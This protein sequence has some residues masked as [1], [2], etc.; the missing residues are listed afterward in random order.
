MSDNPND[1]ILEGEVK[2]LTITSADQFLPALTLEEARERYKL[3]KSFISEQL[4][5]DVDYGQIPGTQ[6]ATLYKA[7]AEK[8]TTFFGLRVTFIDERTVENW[9]E[10]NPLFFYQRKCQLW[11][12]D[13]LIAEASG[14]ANSWEGRYR[15]RWV[16]EQDLTEPPPDAKVRDGKT[17][18][19]KWQYEKRVTT[20]QYGK[21]ETY[22]KSL[23]A[24][25]ANEASL[26]MAMQPWDNKEA[27]YYEWGEK[28]YRIPNDDIYSL[29]NT[30]LKMAEKRALVAA[31][32]IAVNASDYFTQDME[33][34]VEGV[35]VSKKEV[36]QKEAV[37]KDGDTPE[38]VIAHSLAAIKE[39]AFSGNDFLYLGK[40]LG[41][42]QGEVME[43]KRKYETRD[44]E[45][46]RVFTNFQAAAQELIDRYK[47]VNS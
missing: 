42:D 27:E 2:E 17:G 15:W 5:E 21:P 12:G 19:F 43:A 38:K 16:K 6:K 30:I 41:Y 25:I 45:T 4:I 3:M 36:A 7:G 34:I 13:V 10:G 35:E 31:T 1:D 44:E 37:K 26:V 14:S 47:E 18:I 28:E 22:W 23:D 33:D 29:V 9:D 32:L 46:K 8:L 40:V 11:K 39:G 20:G 24:I